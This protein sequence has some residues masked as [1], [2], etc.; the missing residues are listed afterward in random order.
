MR[1]VFAILFSCLLA[2][3]LTLPPSISFATGGGGGGGGG[4][5]DTKKADTNP[6]EKK[7]PAG[8]AIGNAKQTRN[9]VVHAQPLSAAQIQALRAQGFVTET[10]QRDRGNQ[11]WESRAS[12][13]S[14]SQWE[15]HQGTAYDV[16]ARQGG[17]SLADA[18]A[19]SAAQPNAAVSSAL[20]DQAWAT[21]SRQAGSSGVG[22]T[23]ALG[24]TFQPDD[25]FKATRA[26]A[27]LPNRSAGK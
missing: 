2:F 14:K 8:F 5:R 21:A 18:A 3:L 27:R 6:E 22:V 19:M 1:G 13:Q 20:A 12:G 23:A 4:G 16:T 24:G 15:K 26:A 17:V 11:A 7:A 10:E 9:Y 25:W